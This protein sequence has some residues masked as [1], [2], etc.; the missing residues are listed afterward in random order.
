MKEEFRYI[1]MEWLARKLPET[2][3]RDVKINLN[4][5]KVIAI[6]GVRRAGKTYLLFD[7][8]KKLAETGVSREN[9]LYI[10]FDDDRLMNLTSR[11]LDDILSAYHELASPKKSVGIFLFLDEIQNVKNW[12]L[13]VRRIYDLKK[14]RIFITGS[15]SKLLSR[16]IATSLVGRNITYVLYPFSFGEFLSAKGIKRGKDALYGEERHIIN[17]LAKEYIMNG[18]FPETAF[19]ADNETKKKTVSAYY[20]AILYRDI[21]SRYRI[22]DANRLEMV[23][24]YAIN[25]YSSSFSTVKLYNYFK[26]QNLGISRQTINNF[27][28]F[29]EQTFLFYRLLQ[30]FKGFKKSNQSRKKLYVVDNGIISLLISNLEYGKLL[31]N[32][33]LIELLRRKE[34]NPSMEINYLNNKDGEVDFVIS[35]GGSVA[36]LIQ[37]TYELDQKNMERELRPLI[38]AMKDLKPK[39]SLL[40]TFNAVDKAMAVEKGIETLTFVQWALEAQDGKTSLRH[41]SRA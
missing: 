30:F 32:A 26:S 17:A 36:K 8:I 25:M 20:D 28:K 11:D 2:V 29:G 24:R 40:I 41:R 35:E 23:F 5:D 22:E 16:E 1:I 6:A 10:N 18:G 12:D 14:Y 38:T 15:S 9:V 34:K 13:W 27:V 39:R 19:E 4:A 33:V 37:V 31:E 21:I 7:T 3:E